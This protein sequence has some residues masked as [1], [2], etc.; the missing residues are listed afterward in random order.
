MEKLFLYLT[1]RWQQILH[2]LHP[3]YKVYLALHVKARG[4]KTGHFGFTETLCFEC[5]K[6][7]VM[8]MLLCRAWKGS[9][10]LH[11]ELLCRFHYWIFESP[12]GLRGFLNNRKPESQEPF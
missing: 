2:S 10:A 7:F 6:T 9:G 5:W 8:G 3:S 11:V 12:Q 1:T 4:L